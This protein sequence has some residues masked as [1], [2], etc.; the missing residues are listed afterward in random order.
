VSPNLLGTCDFGLCNQIG[1][2]F[3]GAD[4][5]AEA[6][7][8]VAQ[9]EVCIAAIGIGYIL[10]TYGPQIVQTV[11]QTVQ[12]LG[13]D[14]QYENDLQTCRRLADPGAR[15]RCFESALN[16]KNACEQEREPLPPLITW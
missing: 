5:V 8:C 3:V 10:I 4:D 11:Q 12:S 14:I 13:C 2:S 6:A 16:R 1:S 15:S 9:P 7:L